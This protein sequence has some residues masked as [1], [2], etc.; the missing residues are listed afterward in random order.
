MISVASKV[1]RCA[2]VS[3]ISC[4]SFNILKIAY[5]CLAHGCVTR[6]PL[7]TQAQLSGDAN[8]KMLACKLQVRRLVLDGKSVTGTHA[9]RHVVLRC[10]ISR[11]GALP[12]YSRAFRSSCSA[13]DTRNAFTFAYISLNA[14]SAKILC[15]LISGVQGT[16]SASTE[17]PDRGH[18]N[19]QMRWTTGT[20]VHRQVLLA[21]CH[22]LQMPLGRIQLGNAPGVRYCCAQD[23]GPLVS[24]P[25]APPAS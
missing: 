22:V 18:Y 6:M 14:C 21:T 24:V 11:V 20:M 9:R 15:S 4:C 3:G 19:C 12:G 10:E 23:H 13:V 1:K 2:N 8:V 5:F 16:L 7:A 25:A 17:L